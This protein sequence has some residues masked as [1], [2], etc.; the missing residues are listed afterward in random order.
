ARWPLLPF[1]E[2]SNAVKHLNT[3]LVVGIEIFQAKLYRVGICRRAQLIHKAFVR[4]DVLH[5]ARRPDPRRPKRRGLQSSAYRLHVG[6]LVGDRR[7]L[8]DVAGG[9]VVLLWQTG[10]G[11]RRKRHE[12]ATSALLRDEEVRLPRRDI[13][14]VIHARTDIDQ[15]W[16]ALWLPAMLV[17]ARP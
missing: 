11:S 10:K 6:E 9:D 12:E 7:V 15:R 16:R 14:G 2:R 17:G 8:E 3:A 4:P 5:A 13:T 1:C